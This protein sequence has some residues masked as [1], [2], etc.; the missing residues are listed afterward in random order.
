MIISKQLISSAW[1]RGF[2][3]DR[4]LCYKCETL[5]NATRYTELKDLPPVLHISLLRFVYDITTYERKKSKHTVIFPAYLD[6]S[7]F[8]SCAGSSTNKENVYELR[9]VLLHKGPSAYHGHYEA[10]VYDTMSVY[11]FCNCTSLTIRFSI[12]QNN[13][14]NLMMKMYLLYHRFMHRIPQKINAF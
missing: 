5:E 2:I 12:V 7:R 6:M 9:G 11:I 1:S 8:L 14:I 13:G 3:Y 4:Y 10:Q